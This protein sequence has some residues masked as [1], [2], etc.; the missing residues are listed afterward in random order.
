MV[1][2]LVGGAGAAVLA[3]ALSSGV[4]LAGNPAGTGQPSVE[5]GDDGAQLSPAGFTTGGFATAEERYA[6]SGAPSI[7]GN[8]DRAISQYDVACYHYTQAHA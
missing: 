2:R 3:L 4:A 7:N 5:C 6:G 8:T 1:R